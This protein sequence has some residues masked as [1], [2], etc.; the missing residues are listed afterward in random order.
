M[1]P[2][3]IRLQTHTPVSSV[4][5][6]HQLFYLTSDNCNGCGYVLKNASKQTWLLKLELYSGLRVA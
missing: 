1:R 5:N 2:V 3:S 6:R 4:L